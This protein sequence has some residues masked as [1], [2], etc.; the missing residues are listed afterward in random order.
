MTADSPI[1]GS[2]MLQMN[3][4]KIQ[5]GAPCLGSWVNY[6]LGSVNENL[7]GFVVML[8]KKGGPIS[9]AKNWASGYMPATYQATLLRSQ[10]DPILNPAPPDDMPL[11]AQRA[12]LD[13]LRQ[14]NSQHFL[15]RGDNSELA[16]RI[17]SYELAWRM[18]EHA[19]EAVDLSQET[20]ETKKLYGLDQDRTAHFGRQCLLARRMV[21]RGVRFV[22]VY[23]GG[24]H[25][26]DNWDAHGDLE[27]NHEFHAGNT[28][29][30]HCWSSG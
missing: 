3:S 5:S 4:G 28:G 16:A 6:G 29:P 17:A 14:S 26:D 18:Q 15:S 1:H 20:V 22:Q 19:P 10:G 9:G 30:T 8:D 2:A 11:A 12:L 27:K 7:P 21:E 13:S 23:S 24:A 25:N